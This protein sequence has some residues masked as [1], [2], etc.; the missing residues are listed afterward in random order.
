MNALLA[1]DMRTFYIK[2][3]L[4]IVINWV[5]IVI[6]PVEIVLMIRMNGSLSKI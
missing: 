4:K 6:A 1:L 2:F 5:A 3:Y